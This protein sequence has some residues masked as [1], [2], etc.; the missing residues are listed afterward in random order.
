MGEAE[1]L[2]GG[3]ADGGR[4][5]ADGVEDDGAGSGERVVDMHGDEIVGEHIWGDSAHVDDQS[6]G[7]R[8]EIGGFEAV[9][10]HDRR[11]ACGEAYIGS[12][13]LDDQVGHVVAEGVGEDVLAGDGGDL[14]DE[15][16]DVVW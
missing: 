1:L 10:G 6:A 4:A 16:G 15:S 11:G 5:A 12:E 9:V 14:G 2:D 7:E 3:A 13:V 8:G